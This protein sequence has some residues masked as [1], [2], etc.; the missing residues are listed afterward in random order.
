M[1]SIAVPSYATTRSMR[2]ALLVLGL[3]AALVSAAVGPAA[4]RG[5]NASG[6]G[7][8]GSSDAPARLKAVIVV[9]PTHSSTATYLERG[10]ALAK[11]AEQYGM[12]VRR[13]FHPRATAE[14]LLA[15]IQGANI[16]AYLG[17]GNGWPSPYAPFQENTKNGMGLNKVEGGSQ[18]D[19]TYYGGNWFRANVTLAQ[20]AI[21]LFRGLCYAEGNGEPGMAKPSWDVAHQRVDNFAAAFLAINARAVFAYGWQ[22]P[23]SVIDMLFTTNKTI[24]E[25]FMT[26]GARAHPSYGFIGWNNKRLNSVRMPGFQNHLDPDSVEGFLRAVTGNLSMTAAQWSGSEP[27]DWTPPPSTGPSTPTGFTVNF[28]QPNVVKMSWNASTVNMIGTVKYR[29]F[30]NGKAI[31][32]ATTALNY[33]DKPAKSGTYN[34]QVRAIDPA[35]NLSELTSPPVPVTINLG[36]GVPEGLTG[37]PMNDRKV[38]LSWQPTTS[39]SGAVKYR[40]FR[41]GTAIGTLQTATTYTDQTSKQGSFKYQVRAVDAAG[42]ASALSPAITVQTVNVVGGSTTDTTPPSVPTGLA[43]AQ[44]E[45][46]TVVLTWNASTDNNGGTIKYR[47]FRNGSAI[48]VQQTTLTYTDQPTTAGTYKYQVRAIDASGNRSALSAAVTVTVGGSTGSGS[49]GS[50]TPDTTPPSVPMGLQAEALGY[51]YV[52]LTW[53]ASTDDRP[54]T[55]EYRLFRGKKRIATLTGTSFTDR[56]ARAGT[57]QYK[58]RAV[59]AAGNR[60]AFSPLV[61]G[62]AV[63]GPLP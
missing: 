43:A 14:R 63:K 21:V 61:A 4:I 8:A 25:I 48:G 13:I 27:I 46:G 29:V 47:V 55:I 5:A 53:N 58:V 20:N 39:P 44:P 42:N 30:R 24:D 59:D 35:G 9:G 3:V 12:D 10:E 57:K 2:V 15:N 45:P 36:P 60:S 41:N 54:G 11:K 52:K 17:H 23:E 32:T 49:S 31:G 37:T 28:E 26:R 22:P 33:T 16:V 18:N 40:V 7:D 62:Q 1:P 56:P 38:A 34:Y 6:S 50:S 19:V 51:R